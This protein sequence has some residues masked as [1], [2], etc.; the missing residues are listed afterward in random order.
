MSKFVVSLTRAAR[1][2]KLQR[3][4]ERALLDHPNVRILEGH[5]RKTFTVTMPEE[6]RVELQSQLTYAVISPY[7]ELELL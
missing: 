4:L 3:D 6:T 5:G 1:A 2:K 7:R